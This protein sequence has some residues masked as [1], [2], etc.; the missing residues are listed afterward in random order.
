LHTSCISE[1]QKYQ[2]ALYKPKKPKAEKATPVKATKPT[3][4]AQIEEKIGVVTEEPKVEEVA[5]EAAESIKETGDAD[6]KQIRKVVK[7]TLKRISAD[8][9]ISLQALKKRIVDRVVEKSDISPKKAGKQLEAILMLK[10][11][12]GKIILDL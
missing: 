1:E 4:I 12:D 2:G 3:L 6:L 7:S 5:K 11:V 9:P 10:E 8:A